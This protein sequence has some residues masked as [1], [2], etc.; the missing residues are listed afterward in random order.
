MLLKRLFLFLFLFF[1]Y[2]DSYVCYCRYVS[3]DFHH[4][5]GNSNFDN[6]QLLFDQISEEFEKQG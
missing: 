2:L 6:L 5:C 1:P 4:I 3:F